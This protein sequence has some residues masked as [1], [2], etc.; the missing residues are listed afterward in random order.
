[1]TKGD[2]VNKIIEYAGDDYDSNDSRQLSLIRGYVDDA[3][4]EVVNTMCPFFIDDIDMEYYVETALR[5]YS[6]V[7][8]RIAQFHYDKQ[9]KEGVVAFSEAGQKT[10]Y[11]KGGTPSQYLEQIIPMCKIV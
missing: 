11:E 8:R 10:S 6:N 5:R 2:I 4:E 7:I 1:M 9:G 3:T